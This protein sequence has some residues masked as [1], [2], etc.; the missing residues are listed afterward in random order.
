MLRYQ[1]YEMNGACIPIEKEVSY[2]QDYVDLQKLRNDENFEVSFLTEAQVKGFTIEPLL[3]IPF[4]ENAFK[5][6]SHCKERLNFIK[7]CLAFKNNE[8]RFVVENSK[9]QQPREPGHQGIGL[10]NVK[11][12][13]ALLYPGRHHLQVSDEHNIFRVELFIKI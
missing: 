3:L 5:H 2:L 13:L 11:R 9:E 12:R 6:L 10:V 8:F 7:I 4:V 1:L